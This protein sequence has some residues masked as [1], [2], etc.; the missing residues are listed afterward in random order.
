MAVTTTLK[1]LSFEEALEVV[2]TGGA[3][4]DL[5]PTAA[6]LDAHVPGSLDVVYEQGPGMSTRARDCLPLDIPYV[7]LD[8]G[9]GDLSNAAASLR[10]K[11]FSVAGSV[12]DGL[13]A[14]AARGERIA[15]TD[16][17]TAAD[18]PAGT[19]LD[20]SDP[21]AARPDGAL[22][23]PADALWPRTGEIPRSDRVVVVT[24]YGVRAGLA[25]GILERAGFDEVALWRPA[26]R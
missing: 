19:V 23:I 9:Y 12:R 14:W 18:P 3:L 1:S 4:L 10:G 17:L 11:G 13:N 16:V 2:G 22:S 7:V 5:R 24:G 25:V 20:V 26:R 8:L 6:Y 15:S 21:G